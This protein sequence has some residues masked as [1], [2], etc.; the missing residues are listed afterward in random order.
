MYI[1]NTKTK[2][3]R[4]YTFVIWLP[5]QEKG[6]DIQLWYETDNKYSEILKRAITI[7]LN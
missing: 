3:M 6:K 7:H 4:R 5:I 1:Y 2:K